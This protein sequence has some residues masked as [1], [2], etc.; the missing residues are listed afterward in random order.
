L[1]LLKSHDMFRSTW[2]SSGDKIKVGGI[3][4]SGVFYIGCPNA[5]VLKV[6]CSFFLMLFCI[7]PCLISIKLLYDGNDNTIINNLFISSLY[8]RVK[9]MFVH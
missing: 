6:C 4:A 7:T 2:P 9:L 3:A 8:V 1:S 5:L